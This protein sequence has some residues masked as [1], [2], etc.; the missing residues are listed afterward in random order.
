M[1]KLSINTYR[2]S[3]D[4]CDQVPPDPDL[5]F[6]DPGPAKEAIHERL[7]GGAAAR[8]KLANSVTG[9]LSAQFYFSIGEIVKKAGSGSSSLKLTGYEFRAATKGPRK[10]RWVVPVP[11]T[12]RTVIVSSDEIAAF[13]AAQPAASAAPQ[14]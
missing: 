4:E 8:A 9:G 11:G 5:W 3:S 14:P 13:E 1:R 7:P 6:L 12:K 10:G 2:A